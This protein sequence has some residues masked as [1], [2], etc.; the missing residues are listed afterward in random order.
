MCLRDFRSRY[1][2]T[3]VLIGLLAS[4]GG[5]DV[6]KV[7]G[8]VTLDGQPLTGAYVVFENPAQGVSVTAELDAAGN[9]SAHT[10]KSAGLPP[11]AYQVA[12]RP[13]S[14]ATGAAPLVG[15]AEPRGS[16]PKLV[17]PARYSNSKTSGLTATVAAGENRPFDFAI[18]TQ[19]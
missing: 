11:G 1:I 15:A 5:E 2:L 9:Y 4:C 12:I 19:P 8:K 17:V 10:F 3:L 14:M 16:G 6:A 18:S 13:G 7:E